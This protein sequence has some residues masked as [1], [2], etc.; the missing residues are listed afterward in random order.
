MNLNLDIIP[1]VLDFNSAAARSL[2]VELSPS[3]GAS[4]KA[5]DGGGGLNSGQ[6]C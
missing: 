4:C 6:G 3:E 5:L 1:R 2:D